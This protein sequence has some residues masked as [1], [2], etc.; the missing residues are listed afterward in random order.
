MIEGF[1]PGEI[2]VVAASF[3]KA[4]SASD[5]PEGY[6]YVTP[7]ADLNHCDTFG[8]LSDAMRSNLYTMG[9]AAKVNGMPIPKTLY[10]APSAECRELRARLILEEAVHETIKALGFTVGNIELT[11]IEG[12]D[13]NSWE[14]I[15]KVI[16]G[17]CDTTVVVKG[18]LA[19]YG[20]PDIPHQAE[21]DRT[22]EAKFPNGVAKVNEYG[23]FLKPEGWT[24]PNHAEVRRNVE[25]LVVGDSQ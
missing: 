13:P 23:K 25:F 10:T 18:T 9:C 7:M 11:P 19:A 16:D 24:P 5:A 15:E 22:N 20:V 14:T 4:R 12:Y 21:V 2:Q 3:G 1:E 17:C 6:E 8:M